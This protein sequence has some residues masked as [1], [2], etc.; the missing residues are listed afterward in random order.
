MSNFPHGKKLHR[1][2]Q[3]VSEDL[4]PRAFPENI[5]QID[6]SWIRFTSESLNF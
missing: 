3:T 4:Q 6:Y 5:H 2:D 1:T